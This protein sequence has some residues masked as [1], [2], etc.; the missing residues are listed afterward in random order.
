MLVVGF[1]GYGGRGLNPAA[2]IVQALDGKILAGRTV[3]GAVLPVS[4]AG[5]AA[6]LA[7]LVDTHEPKAMICLG[8]WP[9]EPMIRLE[10]VASNIN[11][12]HMTHLS[13]DRP[14]PY[15]CTGISHEPC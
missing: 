11:D 15:P 3:T 4:Y 14:A 9:G 7:D 8:L 10:R 5:L 2:E 6:A 12:F 1:E 13:V